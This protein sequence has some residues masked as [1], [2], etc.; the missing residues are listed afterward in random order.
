MDE[1]LLND[2]SDVLEQVNLTLPNTTENLTSH[3]SNTSKESGCFAFLRGEAVT[4]LPNDLYIPPEA[5][6]IVLE[7]FEGPLDLLLYLIKKHNLDILN[8]PVAE[9]TR[10]YMVYVEVMTV[11]RLELAADYLEM[12]A[13]LAE[14]KSRMLLPKSDQTVEEEADPRA[15]LVRRLQEYERFKKVAMDLDALPREGREI[16]TATAAMP[17]VDLAK[18]QPHVDLKEVLLAFKEV[19]KR[20]DM[21]T[22]HTV[23]RET[24]S[25]REHMSLIL[26]RLEGDKFL[27]F[28]SFL[29]YKQGRLGIVVTFLAVLELVR[30]LMVEL[31][32][33][34]PFGPIYVRAAGC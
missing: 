18:P 33:N 17:K 19:L 23:E 24:L 9:I 27:D 21:L 14:I 1:I 5:L 2:T 3:A 13:L 31:V 34:E 12:A 15:E 4:T 7:I 25:V 28:V 20:A 6:E 16:F 22:S 32:Q 30:E 10:Q 8:I 26:S 29:D 11:F